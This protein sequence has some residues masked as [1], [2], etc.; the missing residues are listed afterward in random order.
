MTFLWKVMGHG[1]QST[2]DGIRRHTPDI[3]VDA[4]SVRKGT[5]LVKSYM[6]ENSGSGGPASEPE[7]LMGTH[8]LDAVQT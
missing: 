2:S 7:K 1:V 6:G 8:V 4:S 3:L 5:M